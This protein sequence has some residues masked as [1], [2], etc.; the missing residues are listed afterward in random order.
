MTIKIESDATTLRIVTCYAPQTGCPDDEKDKFWEGLDAHLRTVGPEEH[1]VLGGDL[2]GHVG[3]ARDGYNQ[4]HGDGNRILDCAEAHELVVANTFFK[5][6]PTHLI[7]YTSGNRTT[8]IDYLLV[9]RRDLKLVTNIKVI[10][11]EPIAPQHR[12]LVMDL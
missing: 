9:R 4:Y 2:N 7:T 3:S 10:P 11:S 8:Q 6:R 5:K 12:P 1:L